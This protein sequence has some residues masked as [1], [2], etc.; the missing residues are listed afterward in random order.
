MPK[1]DNIHVYDSR[2]LSPIQ[3]E[4]RHLRFS[5][6]ELDTKCLVG[7]RKL[8]YSDGNRLSISRSMSD[9]NDPMYVARQW[10]KVG[11]QKYKLPSGSEVL[12]VYNPD[13]HILSLRECLELRNASSTN[14]D[15][16]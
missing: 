1:N 4:D 15:T 5:L 6:N 10:H 2:T 12:L 16:A 8:W 7:G 13:Y 11:V 3:K 9:R 14:K